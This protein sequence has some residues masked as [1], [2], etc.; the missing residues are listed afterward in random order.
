MASLGFIRHRLYA[1]T[2]G[3][4]RTLVLAALATVLVV[5]ASVV[6][7]PL[8]GAQD[9][10]F[11]SS[12]RRTLDA[13]RIVVRRRVEDRNGLLHF[14]G[15]SFQRIDRPI[16]EVWRAIREPSNYRS[17]LPQVE[18]VRTVSRGDG[19]AVIR[20]EH[21]YS[22]VH[23]AYHLRVR[24]D[25]ARRD[26]SF[27]LDS[28]RPNDVRAARGFCTLARWPGNDGSTLVTWGILAAVDD[29][30]VGSLVRP[31]LHDWMLRVPTTMRSY[32]QGAGR[33][34]FL[35]EGPHQAIGN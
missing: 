22:I 31:Q 30:L 28:R 9:S 26:L 24:F 35:A 15:T 14:G 7:R 32:L 12:E 20:L 2:S 25:D 4:L 8:V 13:G 3:R 23:A 10:G 1:M 19:E 17:L 27:D 18:S 34:L 33:R 5:G 6:D 21:A 11:S 16:D 29:G